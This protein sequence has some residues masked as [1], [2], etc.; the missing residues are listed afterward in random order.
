MPFTKEF[1]KGRREELSKK[2]SEKMKGKKPWNKGKKGL[3]I[4]WNKGT[5]GIMKPNKT[6]FRKGNNLG[7]NAHNWKGDKVSYGAL[8]CWIR[9]YLGKASNYLCSHCD[10]N[11]E[12]WA[13]IS[14][15]YKRDLSDWMPLCILCHRKYDKHSEKIRNWWRTR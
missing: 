10:K 13:N 5:K 11:A 9:R 7:T 4:A 6:S 12:N 1:W 14:Q 2:I 8:H 3:Q 15:Q